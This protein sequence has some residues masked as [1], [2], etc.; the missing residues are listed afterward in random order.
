VSQKAQLE[1]VDAFELSGE[2]LPGYVEDAYPP[3]ARFNYMLPRPFQGTE[4][5]LY[6]GGLKKAQ[7]LS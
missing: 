3:R 1:A 5:P 2:D 7:C 6:S 4:M